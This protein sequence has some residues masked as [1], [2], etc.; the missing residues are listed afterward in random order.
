MITWYTFDAKIPMVVS[1][2]TDC[3]FALIRNRGNDLVKVGNALVR[4]QTLDFGLPGKGV[5]HQKCEAPEGPFR[6]LVSDPFSRPG[7]TPIL[8]SDKALVRKKLGIELRQELFDL[9]D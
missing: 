4:C 6:I 3:T 7:S 2:K 1:P 9:G 5:R 8:S